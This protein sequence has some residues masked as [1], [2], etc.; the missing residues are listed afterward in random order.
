M[1]KTVAETGPARRTTTPNPRYNDVM[2]TNVSRRTAKEEKE[3]EDGFDD[4]FND[5]Q[6]DDDNDVVVVMG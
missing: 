3:E 5:D 1:G 4:A 6:N 2:E